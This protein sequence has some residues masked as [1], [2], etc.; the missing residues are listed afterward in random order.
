MWVFRRYD[1]VLGAIICLQMW[2]MHYLL[3]CGL[4]CCYLGLSFIN[5]CSFPVWI[6]AGG[7]VFTSHVTR[8]TAHDTRP[9]R[10]HTSNATRRTPHVQWL[11]WGRYS[12]ESE[13]QPAGRCYWEYPVVCERWRGG[14]GLGG[15]SQPDG[16]SPR[17][18]GFQ[19]RHRERCKWEW[20]A[21]GG[22]CSIKL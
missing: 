20:V 2:M 6:R 18:P 12:Q 7:S 21:W 15:T 16:W 3:H 5:K 9:V 13:H 14:M 17:A 1:P 22:E 11:G 10:C 8:N 19:F 4:G